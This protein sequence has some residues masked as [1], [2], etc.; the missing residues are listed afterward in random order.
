MK[1]TI[2]DLPMVKVSRLRATGHIGPDTAFTTIRFDDG[3]VEYG[4]AVKAVQMPYG[5]PPL[6][7]FVCPRCGG[8]AQRLRLLDDTPACGKCVRGAGLRY[9][10]EMVSHASK[11]AA[12][13]EP[14]RMAK[15]EAG[16]SLKVNP[17][18]GRKFERRKNLELKVA[19]AR[20][21]ER[22]A[23]HEFYEKALKKL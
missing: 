18:P 7:K 16:V 11:R 10:T 1:Q 6:S 3:E 8:N 20:I 17:L 21:V 14:G 5:R 4:V 12:L 19:R 23:G 9:K 15:L 22:Q 2:D 13:T